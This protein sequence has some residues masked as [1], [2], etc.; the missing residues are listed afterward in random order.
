MNV[1]PAI[2]ADAD[3]IAEVH[4]RSWQAA[5]RGQIPDDH[6]DS[7]SIERRA[8]VWKEML[9][10][11]MPDAGAFVLEDG[12]GILG[13]AHVSPSRD[14]DAPAS[15]GELTAIYLAPDRR[16]RGG[17]RLLIDIAITSLRAAG[18]RRVTLWVLDSNAAARR[19]YERAG[20]MADGGVKTDDRGSF[21]LVELRYTRAL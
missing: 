2:V 15:T 12:G 3:A 9:G 1:R 17:G 7:L 11:E 4:V 8:S 6:L 20:W 16:G 5:Y 18:F 14:A 13:F 21:A 10:R 19:F